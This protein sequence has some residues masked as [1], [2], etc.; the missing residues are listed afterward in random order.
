MNKITISLGPTMKV[1]IESPDV[2]SLIRDSIFWNDLPQKCPK[3]GAGLSL[4]YRTPKDYE[5]YGFR[6]HGPTVHET[7]FG[8]YKDTS[9]GL[10]YKHDEWTEAYGGGR[11]GGPSQTEQHLSTFTPTQAMEM[12]DKQ[13]NLLESLTRKNGV[14]VEEYVQQETGKT[15][16]EI[17]KKEASD[18]IDVLKGG[19]QQ[20]Q[21]TGGQTSMEAALQT[22][23]PSGVPEDDIPF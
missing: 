4:T 18:L 3:C 12:T 5:Y 21:Y 1:E 19:S 23:P 17:S 15:V 9:R 13:F 7:T 14:D 6:C 8:E 10:Y 16:Y 20:S 2:K 22:P 11:E